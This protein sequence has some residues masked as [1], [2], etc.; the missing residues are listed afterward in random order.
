MA[1]LNH[2]IDHDI[3]QLGM[4]EIQQEDNLYEIIDADM[5]DAD[6][7]KINADWEKTHP[8]PTIESDKSDINK[9]ITELSHEKDKLVDRWID[10]WR[11]IHPTDK[12]AWEKT[13]PKPKL[14]PG[15]EKL[16]RMKKEKKPIKSLD[17]V[18]AT[19]DMSSL[20]AS[21]DEED[22]R[23]YVENMPDKKTVY[24]LVAMHG[25]PNRLSIRD[26]EIEVEIYSV[27]PGKCGLLHDHIDTE[28]ARINRYQRIGLAEKSEVIEEYKR[29]YLRYRE[30]KIQALIRT[31]T[32]SPTPAQR[33]LLAAAHPGTP[34]GKI[35][36]LYQTSTP[37][38]KR[39]A[40]FDTC[41]TVDETFPL[42]LASGIYVVATSYDSPDLLKPA[43]LTIDPQIVAGI[44]T[45]LKMPPSP[46]NV[47]LMKQYLESIQSMN[48]L[49]VE[50]MQAFSRKIKGT[51][52]IALPDRFTKT[53]RDEMGNLQYKSMSLS[54]LLTYFKRLGFEKVVLLDDSCR[55]GFSISTPFQFMRSL[56]STA[57]S[58]LEPVVE[59]MALPAMRPGGS[60]R[61]RKTKRKKSRRIHKKS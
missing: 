38:E 48:L 35:Q 3:E 4:W 46:E 22:P 41:Y 58:S 27:D 56:E 33:D 25:E 26:S 52:D 15:F 6:I 34:L 1:Q 50:T 7:E 53:K 23:E 55:A 16:L 10:E 51:P 8:I 21:I 5:K 11:T 39:K 54:S 44:L 24:I 43:D 32:T 13:H 9:R 17:S 49:H 40:V 29:E 42:S 20:L 36:E 31:Y 59:R 45:H 19:F 61:K 14:N 60:K 12:K 37:L 18:K 30:P 47:A 57:E 28:L 2:T